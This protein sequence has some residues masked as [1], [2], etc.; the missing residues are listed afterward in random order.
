MNEKLRLARLNR[1]WSVEKAAERI[2]IS[3][4]TYIRWEKGAQIPHISSVLLACDAFKLSAEE[5]GFQ[6]EVVYSASVCGES[7]EV[8]PAHAECTTSIQPSLIPTP[9]MLSRLTTQALLYQ[10]QEA[11]N[12]ANI[13][14]I[15]YDYVEVEI[16]AK[17]LQWKPGTKSVFLLQQFVAETIRKYDTMQNDPS[18]QCPGQEPGKHRNHGN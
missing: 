10:Q 2:G 9:E 12:L 3:R 8:L 15:G 7:R 4:L 6:A 1:H 14:E 18:T 16:M 11:T 13:R 17:A 5:L